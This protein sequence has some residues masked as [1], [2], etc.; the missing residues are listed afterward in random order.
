VI[1]LYH[2]IVADSSPRERWCVGQALPLGSFIRQIRWLADAFPIVSLSEYL[3]ERRRARGPVRRLVTLTF[4]DGVGS[5]F[6]RVFPFLEENRLP[7]TFFITTGHLEA[8]RL[9]WFCY[10]NALCFEN[11][12]DE[13][14]CDGRTFPLRTLTE[15]IGARRELEALARQR[16]DPTEF[17]AEMEK[18]YPLSP[19]LQTEYGGMSYEELRIAANCR[20]LEIGSHTVTHPFLSR[21]S[22]ARQAPQITES[23]RTLSEKTGRT[24]RYFAHPAGDYD[25]VTLGLLRE[26]GFEAGFATISRKLGSDDTFELDRIGVYSVP[27]WKVKLKAWGAVGLAR[28]LGVRIG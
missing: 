28:R 4:D 5:T 6:R 25:R 15:R 11:G 9:L 23:Q 10:L 17:T 14:V 16:E 18:S 26:T 24:I 20:N 27:L 22:R 19:D 2:R 8:G 3:G 7:A 1:F 21:M 13:V 12:Y